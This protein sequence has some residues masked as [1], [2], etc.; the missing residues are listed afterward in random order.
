M[1]HAFDG[2]KV[3]DKLEVMNCGGVPL[4]DYPSACA[5]RCDQCSAIIGSIGQSARCKRINEEAAS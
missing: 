5:Y 3:P 1:P 2:T 4:W